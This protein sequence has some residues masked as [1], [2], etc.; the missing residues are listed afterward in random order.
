V[1]ILLA[2]ETGLFLIFVPW[3][4]TWSEFLLRGYFSPL[5]PILLNHYLRGALGGLGVID[6]WVGISTAVNWT[7]GK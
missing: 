6:L 5:R 7:T 1:L 2:L 3:S 4:N